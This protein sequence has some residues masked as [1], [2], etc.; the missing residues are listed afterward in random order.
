VTRAAG[1]GPRPPARRWLLALPVGLACAL[2]SYL[3]APG[4]EPEA[5]A[6]PASAGLSGPPPPEVPELTPVAV[7][8][9]RTAPGPP[10]G[11]ELPV[12]FTVRRVGPD[13]PHALE[14][15]VLGAGG[16]GVGRQRVRLRPQEGEPVEAETDDLG[17]FRFEELRRGSAWLSLSTEPLPRGWLPPLRSLSAPGMEVPVPTDEALE[18]RLVRAAL[19]HG[20]VRLP[21][22]TPAEGV[23]VHLDPRGRSAG[24]GRAVRTDAAGYFELDGAYPVESSVSVESGPVH[25]SLARPAPVALAVPEGAVLDVGELVLGGGSASLEARLVDRD[26]DPVAGLEWSCHPSEQ[27]GVWDRHRAATVVTDAEGRLRIEGLAAGAYYLVP[28]NGRRAVAGAEAFRVELRA[29]TRTVL[30]ER[31]VERRAPRGDG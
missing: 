2:V 16:V 8:S 25:A 18:L 1:A 21:D 3:L 20:Y 31:V 29:R 23:R 10:A 17:R 4:R 14:G 24:G 7:A 11:R 9:G 27:A 15:R 5:A 28:G 13:G 19:V 22:G 12:E 30:D 26:G 6:A